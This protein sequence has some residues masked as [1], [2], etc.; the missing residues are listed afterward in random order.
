LKSVA[1]T[2][3][4]LSLD[5]PLADVP[6][7]SES[8]AAALLKG[9]KLAKVSDLLRHFPRRY[10]DRR[11]FTLTNQAV[12]G[13]MALIAG[14][15]ISAEN[16]PTRSRLVITKAVVRDS[17]GTASLIFFNQWYLKKQ[18]EK[19]SGQMIVA[20]GRAQRSSFDRSLELTDVE[21]EALDDSAESLSAGR[22]VPIYPGT[23]G[24]TQARIRKVMWAAT[25]ELGDLVVDP[26]PSDVRERQNLLDLQ[27]AYRL[28]HFPETDNDRL[29]SERRFAFEQFF[30]LQILLAARKRKMKQAFGTSFQDT[31]SPIAEL[32]A[33]LPFSLTGAQLRVIDEVA[34]DMRSNEPMNRLIQGDVGSGKTVVAMAAILIAIRND[35]QAALMA[36]T[37]ILAEQHYLT[38]HRVFERAGAKVA[39]L[40]G[41][42][43]A[44]E[45][46]AVVTGAATG[47]INVVVGTHALIQS[48]IKFSKLGLAVVDEQHRF[49]VVQRAALRE[50]GA[51]PDMLVM[52]ATPIPRTLT[53]TVYGDL[54]V[55]I[56]DELPAGRKPVRTHCKTIAERSAVYE[57]VRG[58]VKEGRQA[59]VICALILESEKLQ[60]RAATELALHL[61]KHVYPEFKIGLLHGQ[62]KPS[63]KEEI[64]VQFRDKKIDLLVA[65][66][67]IEV[68]I[69][70]PNASVILVEDADRFGLAQLHQLRGRVGR[71]TAQSYCI[72]IADPKTEEGKARLK[73]LQTNSD[74]FKIA[75]EDLKLRGPGEFLGTRQSGIDLLPFVD[76][77][78]DVPLLHDARKEAFAVFSS[79]P[80]LSRPEHEPLRRELQQKFKAMI[81]FAGTN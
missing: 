29:Q 22:I 14:K 17:S 30:G 3:N 25:Q 78:R 41:S 52:T 64:M 49:G 58:L 23:E 54:D 61:S 65:T 60:A 45:K 24:V 43:S 4:R 59:Y 47:E 19:L 15:V 51:A 38:V 74:G 7:I 75:E 9:C 48:D 73:A 79:D 8:L 16:V 31:S 39:L 21:W 62:L 2:A 81:E 10:E 50:K 36:P 5:S 44:K 11:S 1:A 80:S 72:L 12:P 57:T 18:L 77:L 67:V 34:A 40:T 26:I 68:G 70:V 37:E 69:D 76:I 33:L 66:T 13:Q 32:T 55:S 42:L 28:I 53:L 6:F 20:Y 56:I 71:G 46:E 63:E 27:S 35:Y